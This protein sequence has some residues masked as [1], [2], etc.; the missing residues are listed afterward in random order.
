[1]RRAPEGLPLR[2]SSNLSKAVAGRAIGGAN[3]E[4]ALGS[5]E[6]VDDAATATC[7]ALKATAILGALAALIAR[8]LFI[9]IGCHGVPSVRPVRMAWAIINAVINAAVE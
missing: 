2:G 3:A 1:M 6:R 5:C 4:V 9:F 8:A 7:R